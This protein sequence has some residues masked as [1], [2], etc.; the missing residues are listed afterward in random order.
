M[1]IADLLATDESELR[2]HYPSRAEHAA[3]G[4]VHA[5]GIALGAV[6]GA[7]LFALALS[8][9]MAPVASAAA[10]YALCLMLML[11]CS[12]IYNLT[13][14]S[15][16]RRV[17]RRLDEAAIF[18]MIAGSYT[19]FLIKLLAPGYDMAAV[20]VVWLLALAGAAGKV[21]R[22]EL[23]DRF[24]CA[25]YMAFAWL[26][27][28]V[29]GPTAARLPLLA[30]ALLAAGGVIYSLGVLIYLNHGLPFRRAIWHALVLIAAASH[31]AAVFTGVVLPGT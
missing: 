8:R 27:A 9:G 1:T 30:L 13:R 28:L 6:G 23:S 19:P 20:A 24:W 16:A 12:A 17:L 11:A 15:P 25:V 18:L 3:D 2:E 4:I 14:P 10:L 31:Y 5:I 21:L 29:I 22:P 7:A 26:S